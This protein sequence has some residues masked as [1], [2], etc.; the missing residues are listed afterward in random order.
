MGTLVS[1]LVIFGTFGKVRQLLTCHCIS[2]QPVIAKKH[3]EI[4]HLP[5]FEV[6]AQTVKFCGDIH[7]EQIHAH[8]VRTEKQQHKMYMT[9]V[10]FPTKIKHRV[11]S[12]LPIWYQSAK[13][14]NF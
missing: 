11:S 8:Y 14:F 4:R 10:K 6:A 5:Y 12:D 9:E 2:I 7:P 3:C 13:V 1:F